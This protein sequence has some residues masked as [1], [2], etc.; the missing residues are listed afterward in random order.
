MRLNEIDIKELDFG[1]HLNDKDINN[2]DD[3]ETGH[4]GRHP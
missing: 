2:E 4:H 1:T 3:E